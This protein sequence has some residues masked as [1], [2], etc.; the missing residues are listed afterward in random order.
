MVILPHV[1]S[2]SRPIYHLYVVRVADRAQ[3]QKD[4]EVAGIGTGIHYPVPLHLAKAYSALGFRPGEFPIAEEV[5][6][7]V[8]SLPM[9]PDLSIEQQKYV[10]TCALKSTNAVCTSVSTKEKTLSTNRG[11]SDASLRF[12]TAQLVSERGAAGHE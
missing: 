2:W 6:S 8:L 4:L 3:L 9:Y 11:P 10:V 5:S 12:R 7:H 1:P